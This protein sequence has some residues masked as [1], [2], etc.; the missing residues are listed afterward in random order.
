MTLTEMLSRDFVLLDRHQRIWD[1]IWKSTADYGRSNSKPRTLHHT[2][3]QPLVTAVKRH[4]HRDQI[5]PTHDVGRID[6][7]EIRGIHHCRRR[8]FG[9]RRDGPLR[10]SI[11]NS[12]GSSYET[13]GL[14]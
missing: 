9:V 10:S 1:W 2:A 6:G 11:V 5:F 13:A 12:A 8:A 4:P 7:V 14:G 3:A